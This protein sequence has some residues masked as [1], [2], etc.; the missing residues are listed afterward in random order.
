PAWVHNTLASRGDCVCVAVGVCA[1]L[2]ADSPGALVQ[3]ALK[4]SER[5]PSNRSDAD[6]PRDGHSHA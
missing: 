1:T 5:L 6:D 2:V 3:R 4:S